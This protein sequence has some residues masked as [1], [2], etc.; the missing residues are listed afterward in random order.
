MNYELRIMK[1]ELRT[2]LL[3]PRRARRGVPL[4]LILVAPQ[5][6][7]D[8]VNGVVG[9]APGAK[10]LFLRIVGPRRKVATPN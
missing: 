2:L 4:R 9:A 8:V 6:I 3:K 1:P 10:Y 5:D 7:L